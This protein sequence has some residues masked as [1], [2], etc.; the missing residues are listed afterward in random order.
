MANKDI[1]ELEVTLHNFMLEQ[2][3]FNNNVGERCLKTE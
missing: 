1:K 2:S 3:K